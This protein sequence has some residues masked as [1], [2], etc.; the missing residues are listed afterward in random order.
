MREYASIYASEAARPLASMKEEV[1][2]RNSNDAGAVDA[3]FGIFWIK[4]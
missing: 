3:L 2:S 1:K 4:K